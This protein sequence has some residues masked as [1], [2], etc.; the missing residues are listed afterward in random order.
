MARARSP[1]RDKSKEM[2]LNSN[3]SLK[4]KDIAADLKV[5]D[6]QIRKWKS[7]DKWDDELKGTL[8]KIKSNVTNDKVTKKEQKKKE[9]KQEIVIDSIK[10]END[11][12]TEKQRLFCLYYIKSFNGTMSAI[13]AGYS[14]ERAHVTASELVRNSKVKAEIR[15]LKGAMAQELFIDAMDVL[16]K[17]VKIAFA[18]IT[19]YVDF[20]SE[21][22]PVLDDEG[23]E[24]MDSK[25]N[26]V[27]MT[28][29][30]VNFKDSSMIDGTIVGEVRKGKDG[31]SVKLND[32]MKSLE[33]LEMYFDLF[34]DKFK[35][36]IEEQKLKLSKERLE[37]ERSIKTKSNIE[38]QPEV[39]DDTELD[40]LL[41]DDIND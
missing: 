28:R 20:G 36:E 12:L 38:S 34:P 25:G 31:V 5:K 41:E 17:Y 13:K 10:I 19:D 24:V 8:P 33:K 21:E 23:K 27:T 15:K 39:L 29:N 26:M 18:D 16:D 1:N 6:S 32:R 40:E 35:R 7:Q 3:G 14:K 2:Y 9:I 30:Y 11:E 4:L 22:V 37:I